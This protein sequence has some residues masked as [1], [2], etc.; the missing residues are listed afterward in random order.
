MSKLRKIL[1]IFLVLSITLTSVASFAFA[2]SKGPDITAESAIIYCGD[3]GEIL[4]EKNSDKKMEPA[5]ITKLLTCLIAAEELDLDKTVTISAE[6]EDIE[7]M[8]MGLYEGEQ[9]TVRELIYG[10]LMISGNDAASALAVAVSGSE[11]AFAEK[12]N[13]RAKEIGCKSSNFVTPSGLPDDKHYSTAYDFALI[14]KAALSNEFIR[15]VSGTVEHTVPATNMSV[16]R[17]LKNFNAFLDGYEKTAEDGSTVAIKKYKGV[18]GGKTGTLDEDYT[19][20]SIGLSHDGMEIYAVLLGASSDERFNDMKKMLDYAKASISKYVAFK[21]GSK[22]EKVKLKGGTTNKVMAVAA[23]DGY[24]NLPEGASASLVTT[25]CI[26][27]DNLTAPIE[28]GQKI[29]VAE[30]YLAEDLVGKVDL[31][32]AEKVQEGWFLSFLGITNFQTIVIGVVLALLLVFAV[33]ILCMRRNNKKK[34][35]AIRQRRLME[36]ARKQLEREEDLRRRNW[37]F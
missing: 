1:S 19:T 8:E 37:H 27:S 13:E 21:K 9:I 31:V 4:W 12:M 36:E 5:S 10:A 15:T 18:F 35:K 20:L 28:K 14:T 2:E 22:F 11:K 17:N 29:G 25:K 33:A 23:E 32:A 26:Y 34:Q 16:A 30:I 24:V 3:T 7:P 6:I